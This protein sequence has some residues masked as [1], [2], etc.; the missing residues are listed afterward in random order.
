MLTLLSLTEVTPLSVPVGHFLVALRDVLGDFREITG[1]GTNAY[2][3]TRVVDENGKPTGDTVDNPPFDQISISGIV[4]G[5]PYAEGAFVN[6]HC[7]AGLRY[8][9][10][11]NKGRTWFRWIIDG[12]EGT[13]EL[14]HREQDGEF[15]SLISA[16]EKTILLNGVEVPLEETELDKL[17]NTAK[18]WYEFSKGENG[19]YTTI[20]DAV[21]I[22]RV[23][24]AVSHSIDEGK[25]I[26][27]L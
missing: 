14:I 19:K 26:T 21:K 8:Y 10:D 25:K 2:P 4:S 17:G 11:E 12:E 6:I 18:A 27:L 22:H 24:D 20:D 9:G 13:I 16:A 7:R 5:K 3:L 1:S 15:G 23:L